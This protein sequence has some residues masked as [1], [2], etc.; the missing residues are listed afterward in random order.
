MYYIYD[1]I[2][3]FKKDYYD[4]FDWNS[5]DK[6]YHFKKV[7]VIKIHFNDYENIKT[8]IVSFDKSFLDLIENKS[9]L[10]GKKKEK[11]KY[12]FIL[13]D[14]N[15]ATAF[16]IDS[17]L[18]ISSMLIEEEFDVLEN[19]Y[20]YDATDIKYGIIKKRCKDSF[21]TRN[22]IEVSSY[23]KNELVK[24]EDDDIEKLK[25]LYYE[26]FDNYE[27]DRNIIMKKLY[28]ALDKDFINVSKKLY[29]FFKLV[30]K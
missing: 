4:F 7:P 29:T 11:V 21:K 20:K 27:S 22:E 30:H 23:L 2:L 28:E 24:L 8:N 13:T 16:N 14:G 5:S 25:Y 6:Y 3:N 12:A 17:N 18:L 10:Y 15:E 19:S 1:I 9:E 26:C